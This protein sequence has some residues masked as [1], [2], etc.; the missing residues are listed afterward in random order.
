MLLSLIN[1][2]LAASPENPLLVGL[3]FLLGGALS[4]GYPFAVI[5]G[6]PAPYSTQRRRRIARCCMALL[7]VVAVTSALVPDLEAKTPEWVRGLAGVPVVIGAFAP[8][9][10]ATSV[11]GDA[12]RALGQYRM[13][14]CVN[15][16]IC[17]LTYPVLGVFFIQR[18]V[19][20]VLTALDSKASIGSGGT[21]AV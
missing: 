7:A 15:T 13:G 4:W 16:W 14:H 5:F 21:I 2:P 9:F 18:D 3:S 12:R 1:Q 6:F 8:F 17:V 10:M 19:A 11:I 20:K